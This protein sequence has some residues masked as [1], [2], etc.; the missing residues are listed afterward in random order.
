MTTVLEDK[1]NEA[2]EKKK[3]DINSFVWKYPKDRSKDNEQVEVRLIDCTQEQLKQ[4]YDHCVSMLHNPNRMTP[5]RYDVLNL[6][7][8]Q[9]DKIGAELLLREL[10]MNPTFTRFALND[11]IT[12]FIENKKNAGIIINPDTAIFGQYYDESL[13]SKYSKLTLKVIIEACNDKLGIFDNSHITKSFL[14]KKGVWFTKEDL[15]ELKQ[16]AVKEGIK[17][18]K[19]YDV[20]RKYLNLKDYQQLKKSSNGLSLQE[21][22]CILTLHPDKIKDLSTLQLETLRYKLLID[23]EKH[24]MVH[25][26]KWEMLLDQIEKV[27]KVKKYNLK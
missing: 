18:F 8:I 14:L 11:A 21:L 12:E 9:K 3:N 23:L 7:R 22:K 24:V 4:F 6:I 27:A 10:E 19:P 13:S 17:D 2:M 1:F 5:G 26:T 16:Y 20:A 25:I 15:K